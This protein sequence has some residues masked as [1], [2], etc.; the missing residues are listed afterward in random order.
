MEYDDRVQWKIAGINH[1]AWVLEIT[2]NGK[3][4]YPQIKQLSKEKGYP[5]GDQVRHEIMHRFGYY[6]TESSEHN[7]EYMPYWIKD[8]YPELIDRFGIPLDEYPRRCI[9]NIEEWKELREK[10]T[11]DPHIT[12][13]RSREYASHI[14]EAMVVNHP[15]KFGGN[16]IN[17]GVIPNLPAYACVEVPCI[18]DASGIAPVYVGNLPEQ[19]AALNRTN[20]NVQLMTIEAARTLKKDAVYHAAY[21]DP[22]TAAEL[23]LD[24]IKSMCDDLFEA[25]KDWLPAYR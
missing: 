2:K 21:L 9:H 25:H 6:V 16:V 19:C 13:E 3:D 8:K 7:A 23:S 5:T 12:H 20:I 11:R 17:N 1:M 14:M 24:D 4:L 10:L 15:Y 18:A 22:H